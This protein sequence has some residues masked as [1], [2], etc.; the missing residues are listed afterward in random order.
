MHTLRSLMRDLKIVTKNLNFGAKKSDPIMPNLENMPD[1]I[2]DLIAKAG[3]VRAN[4]NDPTARFKNLRD[5]T[6]A[7]RMRREK[8]EEKCKHLL[9]K[10]LNQ[11]VPF[12]QIVKHTTL[13]NREEV[14][15]QQINEEN[16]LTGKIIKETLMKYYNELVEEGC[17]EYLS[18]IYPRFRR[19]LNAFKRQA[20]KSPY[21]F[22]LELLM[23]N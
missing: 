18:E 13:H 17:F 4:K 20:N 12:R 23:A 15:M 3:R 11:F 14:F 9:E 19:A 7:L 6:L 22:L 2:I 16:L 5:L 1:D 8:H 10:I 21:R